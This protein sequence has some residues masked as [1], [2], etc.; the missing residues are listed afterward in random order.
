MNTEYKIELNFKQQ[1][2]FQMLSPYVEDRVVALSKHPNHK[3]V[4]VLEHKAFTLTVTSGKNLNHQWEED[5]FVEYCW[6][7][8]DK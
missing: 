4:C 2:S 3:E 1:K 7:V 8:S 6:K 5:I